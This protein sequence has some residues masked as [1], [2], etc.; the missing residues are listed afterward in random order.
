[1]QGHWLQ[2]MESNSDLTYEKIAEKY[3]D[4]YP[5][6]PTVYGDTFRILKGDADKC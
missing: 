6:C 4:R 5:K 3:N 2:A 1:M